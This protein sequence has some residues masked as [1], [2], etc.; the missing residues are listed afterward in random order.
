MN[1]IALV[2]VAYLLALNLYDLY[3]TWYVLTHGGSETN[4]LLVRLRDW[5]LGLPFG[6]KWLWLVVA[7]FWVGG[8]VIAGWLLGWWAGSGLWTLV[9]LAA[10]YSYVML[11][12]YDAVRQ[13]K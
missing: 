3:S 12:N 2:L 7:K 10:F 6:G 9:C 4:P 11:G 5:M 13:S 8:I 1:K